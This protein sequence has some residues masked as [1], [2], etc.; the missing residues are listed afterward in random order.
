MD[1]SDEGDLP[2]SSNPNNDTSF[3]KY[4]DLLGDVQG[5]KDL[6]DNEK[7]I[8]ETLYKYALT[9]TDPDKH[10]REGWVLV[11]DMFSLGYGEYIF[12]LCRTVWHSGGMSMVWDGLGTMLN[13]AFGLYLEK[14]LEKQIE[15]I[16]GIVGIEDWDLDDF[17]DV[18]YKAPAYA[19]A[20]L[21][22]L[23]NIGILI[24]MV[25]F[26]DAIRNAL[27]TFIFKVGSCDGR[28]AWQLNTLWYVAVS[29]ITKT[30]AYAAICGVDA[31]SVVPVILVILFHSVLNA[32]SFGTLIWHI[33]TAPRWTPIILNQP[34]I[35]MALQL[36]FDCFLFFLNIGDAGYGDDDDVAEVISGSLLMAILHFILVAIFSSMYTFSRVG[37]DWWRVLGGKCLSY[38]PGKVL[39]SLGDGGTLP[40]SDLVDEQRLSLLLEHQWRLTRTQLLIMLMAPVCIFSFALHQ[41]AAMDHNTATSVHVA[42]NG[43]AYVTVQKRVRHYMFR[44]YGSSGM[45]T[46]NKK[47]VLALLVAISQN[48]FSTIDYRRMADRPYATLSHRGNIFEDDKLTYGGAAYSA[49]IYAQLHGNVGLWIDT[50][51]MSRD[52]KSSAS[53]I[54]E[55][56]YYYERAS[57]VGIAMA[58]LTDELAHHL[59]NMVTEPILCLLAQKTNSEP[60][61]CTYT[62]EQLS[63]FSEYFS[64]SDVMRSAWCAQEILSAKKLVI[65]T[66][67]GR[68]I[69]S[70]AV[71]AGLQHIHAQSIYNGTVAGRLAGLRLYPKTSWWPVHDI[72]LACK[73]TREVGR[74]DI[75]AGYVS[76][77]LE[78]TCERTAEAVR[79]WM[80]ETLVYKS[81]EIMLLQGYNSATPGERWFG[82]LC[83]PDSQSMTMPL[84][85]M[86]RVDIFFEVHGV[87][88]RTGICVSCRYTEVSTHTTKD[89]NEFELASINGHVAIGW[90]NAP[91]AASNGGL[92]LLLVGTSSCSLY[93][94]IVQGPNPSWRRVGGCVIGHSEPEWKK[95]MFN[96]E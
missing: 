44:L 9:A 73:D 25:T 17:G 43:R 59:G 64:F 16:R 88:K 91:R 77:N 34:W 95:S 60:S 31:W 63:A 21:L 39:L 92:R 37:Q 42:S 22:I 83:D 36:I 74:L 23:A 76:D 30:A 58:K 18:I 71:M 55:Q 20:L 86:S 47:P 78:Y 49:T 19:L 45:W 11:L 96:I 67:C 46:S 13:G 85:D 52:A 5:R 68:V 14:C 1:L 89:R 54:R 38:M 51:C 26:P 8:T 82:K 33:S 90:L 27:G 7:I 65:F 29:S 32:L 10:M 53:I 80:C 24:Y 48:G 35:A 75:L 6:V 69:E 57:F 87:A 61:N 56:R 66:E 79:K 94:V 3:S 72:L 50:Y 4:V 62:H 12:D 2:I 28:E 93:C 41:L 40:I 70:S 84:E 15:T 81:P